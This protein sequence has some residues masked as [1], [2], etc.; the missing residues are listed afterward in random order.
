[1]LALIPAIDIERSNGCSQQA[2]S[3]SLKTGIKN[4]RGLFGI[5]D[6][7]ALGLH[8]AR[9]ICQNVVFDASLR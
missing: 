8:S 6:L 7:D 1:M 9:G 4:E 3:T 5:A 2:I